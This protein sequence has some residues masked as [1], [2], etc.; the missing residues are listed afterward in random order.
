MVNGLPD[1]AGMKPEKMGELVARMSPALRRQ[2]AEKLDEYVVSTVKKESKGAI[3]NLDDAWRAIE[4]IS[5]QPEHD[6]YEKAKEAM[7]MRNKL[8]GR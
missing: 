2:A 7:R 1:V 3:R 6:Q 5:R 8:N 4:N